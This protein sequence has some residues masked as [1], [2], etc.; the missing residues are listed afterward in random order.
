MSLRSARRR[1]LRLVPVA[2]VVWVAASATTHVPD[3]AGIVAGCLWAG[4]AGVLLVAARLAR[5]GRAPAAVPA[6]RPLRSEIPAST[7]AS[8]RSERPARAPTTVYTKPAATART[9]L[10]TALA[11]AAVALA[12]GGG[13]ATQVAL[14]QPARAE[15]AQL[16]V[17]GGR[18][19]TIAAVVVGKVEPSATGWR[20]DALAERIRY[21][22]VERAVSFPVV[23]H[24]TDRPDELDLGASITVEGTARHAE[25]GEREVL[26]VRAGRGI[27][28]R[29]PPGGV[30]AAATEL[31]RGL[32][33]ATD[34]L[35]QPAAG[36][37]AGLAVGDTSLVTEELD[38]AMKA[39]S[40]AHL[41]AVSGAAS[42]PPETKTNFETGCYFFVT[43]MRN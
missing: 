20:L 30:L 16:A 31:R 37:V 5:T 24:A 21:G 3:V 28:V 13:A 1:D 40:L 17:E 10:R 39:S 35:P 38:A 32:L 4:A 11:L 29:A 34:G 15:A 27:H 43:R 33:R 2:A 8:R 42:A 6:G 36:L 12:V 9:P 41:T 7:H 19:V 26:V 14:A 18:A 25:P 23:V 22:P